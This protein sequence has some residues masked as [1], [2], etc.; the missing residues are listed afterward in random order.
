MVTG[1]YLG[2]MDMIGTP[3]VLQKYLTTSVCL[4][5]RGSVWLTFGLDARSVCQDPVSISCVSHVVH[6]FCTHIITSEVISAFDP[7]DLFVRDDQ[8]RSDWYS[9]EYTT[10]QP[11]FRCR[12]TKT[13]GYLATIGTVAQMT[14]SGIS[15]QV[16]IVHLDFDGCNELASLVLSIVLG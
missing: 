4:N 5:N 15:K 11:T 13:S 7:F 8:V 10:C 2:A 14:S 16:V 1:P 3:Q 6:L 12:R 9:C